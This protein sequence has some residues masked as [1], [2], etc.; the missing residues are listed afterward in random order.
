MSESETNRAGAGSSYL[1]PMSIIIAGAFIAGAVYFS[2][3]IGGGQGNTANVGQAEI[4]IR[5][6]SNA[7]HIRGRIDADIIL[8][9]YSDTECPYCKEY[10][11]TLKQIMATYGENGRVA[12]VYRNFP[13]ASLHS[14]APKQAEALECAAD[15][16]GNEAF[17]KYADRLYEI[18]PSNNKLEDSELP[19]I[20]LF[21]G[22]NKAEFEECLSSGKMA[23]KVRKDLEDAAGSGGQGTP[24]TVVLLKNGEKRSISGYLP[25]E[26]LK[27]GIDSLLAEIDA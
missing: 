10:H 2:G 17:W 20:A 11:K 1:V 19:N 23:D 24:H 25:Y 21:A 14:K 26:Q 5:K 18:T 27:G 16:G 8:V 13:I 6:V 7:D 12:W 4:K 3:G 22:L 15:L 9:E